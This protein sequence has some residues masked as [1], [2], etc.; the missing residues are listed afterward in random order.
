MQNQPVD[1]PAIQSLLHVNPD[2]PKSTI[3]ANLAQAL[4]LILAGIEAKE[5]RQEYALYIVATSMGLPKAGCYEEAARA[6]EQAITGVAL[7]AAEHRAPQTDSP[8]RP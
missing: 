8:S 7:P 4:R 3:K 6:A 2:D 1:K 5:F